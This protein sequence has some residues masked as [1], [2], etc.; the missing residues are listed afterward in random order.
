MD[1]FVLYN[2]LGKED[3]IEPK[4]R[5]KTQGQETSEGSKGNDPSE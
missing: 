2:I 1:N 3:G 5:I 4:D